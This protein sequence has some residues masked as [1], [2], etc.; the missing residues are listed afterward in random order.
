MMSFDHIL[1]GQVRGILI[2]VWMLILW[3]VE[4]GIPLTLAN[5]RPGSRQKESG[6]V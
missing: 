5:K 1:D 2:F 4:Q 6:R 3:L